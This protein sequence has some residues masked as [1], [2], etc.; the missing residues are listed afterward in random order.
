M[1]QRVAW[2]R[3]G[4]AAVLLLAAGVATAGDQ[5]REGVYWLGT[6][7]WQLCERDGE[8]VLRVSG[9]RKG[10]SGW[11]PADSRDEWYVSAPTI[12]SNSGKFLGSDPD[13]RTPSVQLVK[14]K[15]ANTR[16]VFDIVA[17]I[18]P[19]PAAGERRGM[20]AG[21][22]G[23]RFRVKMDEGPFKGW[24]LA[25]EETVTEPKEGGKGKGPATRRL[26]LVRAA[27][28]ATVFTYIEENYFVDHK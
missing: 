28:D 2:Q 3:A 12:K 4:L 27:K 24:Y 14:D 19:G 18:S 6:G 9:W 16:W 17:D 22:S 11:L 23:F 26:K 1:K 10:K 8:A 5:A 20:K 13:G 25:A 15:G 7:D 21:P